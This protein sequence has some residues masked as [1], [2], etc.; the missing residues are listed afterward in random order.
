VP[1]LQ[2]ESHKF[3]MNILFYMNL[4]EMSWYWN[5]V[6]F[7]ITIWKHLIYYVAI[8]HISIHKHQNITFFIVLEKYSNINIYYAW[9][10][11]LIIYDKFITL[12]SHETS[13]ILGVEFITTLNINTRK[14][15]HIITIYKPST[16]LLSTFMNQLQKLLDV[17]IAYCSTIIRVISTF[18][19]LTK[20]QRNQMNLNFLWIIIQ[21]NFNL[22][23]F[24]TIYGT[25][26]G[27]IWT[28]APTQQYMFGCVESYWNKLD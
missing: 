24:L 21:W 19:S 17:M 6:M 25:H 26:I 11:K 13:T 3:C 15:I 20:T 28:N 14:I 7:F 18:T 22:N 23:F 2:F 1:Y 10:G 8:K 5:F 12:S 27:H 9:N 4:I 16:L